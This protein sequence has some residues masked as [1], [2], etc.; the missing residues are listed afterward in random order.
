MY[1]NDTSVIPLESPW[2]GV[3][4]SSVGVEGGR[5]GMY[6]Y[7]HKKHMHVNLTKDKTRDWWFPY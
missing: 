2:G 3:K 5:F 1:V 7:V 6:E 4:E